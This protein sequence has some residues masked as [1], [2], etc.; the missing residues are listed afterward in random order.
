[1]S[2]ERSS[3]LRYAWLFPLA[4]IIGCQAVNNERVY[5]FDLSRSHDISDV[6][7]PRDQSGDTLAYDGASSL[8]LTLP[9]RRVFQA[10]L[11][12]LAI[13]RKGSLV[14]SIEVHMPNM[15]LD[16]VFQEA[17]RLM[18]AWHFDDRKFAAWYDLAKR[19]DG[20]AERFETMRNDLQPALAL[21]VLHSFNERRP[22]FISFEVAW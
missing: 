9:G 11:Q 17:N 16:E 2:A 5:N 10:K 7:W 15:S 13:V 20:R 4:W 12:Q 22:W 21:K 3:G 1:M 18:Q 6:S 14:F 19:R 8:T